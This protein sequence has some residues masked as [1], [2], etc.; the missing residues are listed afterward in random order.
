MDDVSMTFH[1]ISDTHGQVPHLDLIAKRLL[2]LD[3]VNFP[4]GVR[5]EGHYTNHLNWDAVKIFRYAWPSLDTAT[6][7]QVRAE[8]SRMLHWCLT[9]SYRPDGSFQE[10]A[11]DDTPDDAYRYGVWFLQ[12]TGYFQ[13]KDRFWTD[14]AFP[15]S[16][17]V[18]IRIESSLKATVLKAQD[19]GKLTRAC[20]L[21]KKNK[22]P[23]ERSM[24]RRLNTTK[25]SRLLIYNAR[26]SAIGSRRSPIFCVGSEA[27]T[28][29]EIL[30][31]SCDPTVNV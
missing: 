1:M 22:D 24:A 10:N 4:A 14:Q 27:V 2:Q 16:Q 3:D 26:N 29:T 5:F 9:E 21:G 6:Q 20:R 12:E 7:Q 11:L 23:C 13:P 19:S 15:D 31:N 25:P 17:A 18:Q 8:I 28:A 30:R